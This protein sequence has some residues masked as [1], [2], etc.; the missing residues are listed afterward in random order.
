MDNDILGLGLHT[1]DFLQRLTLFFMGRQLDKKN[2]WMDYPGLIGQAGSRHDVLYRSVKDTVST[3]TAQIPFLAPFSDIMGRGV[4]AALVGSPRNRYGVPSQFG[5]MPAGWGGGTASSAFQA[6]LRLNSQR[7]LEQQQ[8]KVREQLRDNYLQQ[9]YDVVYPGDKNKNKR[10]Q[11]V[12]AAKNNPFGLPRV[13]SFA[14]DPTQ[15]RKQSQN[16]QDVAHNTLQYGMQSNPLDINNTRF[17]A[18]AQRTAKDIALQSAKDPSQ[19]GGFTPAAVTQ[20]TNALSKGQDVFRQFRGPGQKSDAA[21]KKA[22]TQFA[23]KVKSFTAALQPLRDIFGNNVQH[24]V[25]MVT[26]LSGLPIGQLSSR[27]VQRYSTN[28]ANTLRATGLSPAAMAPYVAGISKQLTR[29]GADSLTGLAGANIGAQL[30]VLGNRQGPSTMTRAQYIGQVT[31][32]YAAGQSSINTRRIAQ[33]YGI[34]V[35]Q[36][37]YKGDLQTFI[38]Q[39]RGSDPLQK[40]MQKAGVGSVDQLLK[41]SGYRQTQFALRGKAIA[42]LAVQEQYKQQAALAINNARWAQPDT[43]TDD[44]VILRKTLSDIGK[45]KQFI[46][47]LFGKDGVTTEDVKAQFSNITDPQRI[48]RLTRLANTVRQNSPQLGSLAIASVQSL[49]FAG[50]QQA[51]KD[52]DQAF[53]DLNGK[54]TGGIYTVL[55][56]FINEN[57]LPEEG[58]QRTAVQRYLTL[59]GQQVLDVDPTQTTADKLNTARTR[60]Q[61]LTK[62][63]G[64]NANIASNVI[65]SAV[66]G[67]FSADSKYRES[68]KT[69]S[70]VPEGSDQYNKALD[71]IYSSLTFGDTKNGAQLINS[72]D[73]ETKRNLQDQ[74]FKRL[75]EQQKQWEKYGSRESYR[76][77]VV[78]QHTRQKLLPQAVKARTKAWLKQV[79]LEK[80]SPDQL[81]QLYLKGGAS[82][83]QQ[84]DEKTRARLNKK[85]IDKTKYNQ[86]KSYMQASVG[87]SSTKPAATLQTTLSSL[88]QTLR[89]LAT[90]VNKFLSGSVTGG[91][92]S[93]KG[94]KK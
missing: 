68:I 28:I 63:L 94:G 43:N 62:A 42:S 74:L 39:I 88:D 61:N 27:Q 8:D 48:A 37:G 35:N 79:K 47:K 36:K 6:S 3:L 17:A 81:S 84:L 31:D 22:S 4:G 50:F 85:N 53:K 71:Y 83:W 21:L 46:T 75:G 23:N 89:I 54:P 60:M 77:Y 86:F 45:N 9:F 91:D 7:Y 1:D 25:D 40:A 52:I 5:F 20:L 33:A 26:A 92:N 2:S 66:S 78:Q 51:Q 57:K 59:F 55:S 41:G 18:L 76:S 64:G 70:T 73:K 12:A 56:N 87:K 69:L 44:Q 49:R 19:Y 24:M 11:A 32:A 29:Y 10:I 67:A 16:I 13:L 82:S 15:L 30:A 58:K 65:V 80:E 38:N 90:A 14:L 93:G 72:L 34:A